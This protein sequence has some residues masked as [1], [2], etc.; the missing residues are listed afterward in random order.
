MQGQCKAKVIIQLVTIDKLSYLNPM[1]NSK[2]IEAC[3]SYFVH[4]RLHVY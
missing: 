2:L 1:Y 3:A 4:I